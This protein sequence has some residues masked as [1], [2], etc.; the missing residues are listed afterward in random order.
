MFF[1]ENGKTSQGGQ[2][3]IPAPENKH[4][5]SQGLDKALQTQ[6][7]QDIVKTQALRL[8][9]RKSPVQAKLF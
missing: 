7:L 4:D 6:Q 3:E 9:A 2:T 8:G 1:R 5:Y